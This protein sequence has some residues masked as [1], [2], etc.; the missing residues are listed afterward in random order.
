[1]K[2]VLLTGGS[3]FVGRQVVRRLI[4]CGHAPVC[5]VRS[6][7]NIPDGLSTIT[8]DDIFA[9]DRTEWRAILDGI[10]T[11]IHAAWYT[12]PGKYLQSPSNLPCLAGTLRMAEAALET[13]VSRFVGIGTC[14]EYEL[15]RGYLS[16]TSP[17]GPE[18]PYAVSKAACWQTLNAILPA[19]GISFAWC[20]LFYLHGE[21][22]HP[23]R[24]FPYLHASL[25]A[26][27][28]AQL[29]SGRQIRDFLDVSEA[30]RRIAA[31]A[32]SDMT[33]AINICSG[34]GQTVAELATAVAERYGRTDLLRF[35]ARPDNLAD[36]PC[37]I[38]E[39]TPI[40]EATSER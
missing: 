27:K 20:R 19:A 36:P 6:G 11:V 7:N 24:L 3:G 10:H 5:L 12:E 28:P 35:G 31:V 40:K 14:F 13:G 29:T 16:T 37:V 32:L 34:R 39:P 15:S 9:L 38:G 33:G 17:L 26:G 21:G 2:R 18:T 1:M 30:G 4:D 25:A 8:C 22:E 23:N